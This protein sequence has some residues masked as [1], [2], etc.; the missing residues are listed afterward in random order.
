MTRRYVR[1]TE[2]LPPDAEFRVGP[3]GATY[4]VLTLEPEREVYITLLDALARGWLQE[5]SA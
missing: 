3:G 5:V 4:L 2:A 1:P